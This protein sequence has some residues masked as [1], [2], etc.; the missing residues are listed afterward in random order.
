VTFLAPLAGGASF[1]AG[2]KSGLH[3]FHP[4]TGFAFLEVEPRS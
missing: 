2:L 4:L 3:K 1:V